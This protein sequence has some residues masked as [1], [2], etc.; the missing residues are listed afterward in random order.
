MRVSRSGYHYW[1]KRVPS[2]RARENSKLDNLIL[3]TPAE[4]RGV[5]GYRRTCFS[6]RLEG[7]ITS[8]NRVQRRMKALKIQAKQPRAW[9]KTTD[10]SHGNRVAENVL[11]RTFLQDEKDRA[12]VI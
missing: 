9:K 1:L 5:Y 4:C 10:S 7:Y 11:N 2:D 3:Q 8:K 6:I 12:W